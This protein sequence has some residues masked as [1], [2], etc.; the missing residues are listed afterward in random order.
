MIF[1][2]Y[3][4]L[5]RLAFTLDSASVAQRNAASPYISHILYKIRKILLFCLSNVILLHIQVYIIIFYIIITLL[6]IVL[7]LVAPQCT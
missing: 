2:L 1:F 4:R 6:H 5:V 3:R 7:L